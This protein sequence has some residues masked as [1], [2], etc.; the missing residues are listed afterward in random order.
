MITETIRKCKK[1]L[2]FFPLWALALFFACSPP[3]AADTLL[4]P[5]TQH[6]Q[7]FY[8]GVSTGSELELEIK[9][10]VKP[11]KSSPLPALAVA[12]DDTTSDSLHLYIDLEILNA[13]PE[14]VLLPEVADTL[15]LRVQVSFVDVPYKKHFDRGKL[16]LVAGWS[17]SGLQASETHEVEFAADSTL[18][19]SISL[20]RVDSFHIAENVAVYGEVL[21]PGRYVIARS[22][23]R[24]QAGTAAPGEPDLVGFVKDVDAENMRLYVSGAVVVITDSTRV[25]SSSGELITLQDLRSGR[26][27]FTI[28]AMAWAYRFGIGM[29]ANGWEF[30]R[31][32]VFV[33]RESTE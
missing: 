28:T 24:L 22:V 26:N 30:K 33:A 17:E 11:G 25:E 1:H 10:N 29:I 9:L 20:T 16:R 27:D 19:F 18:V 5:P 3:G 23:R 4:S 7:S 31:F 13:G 8:S 6:L 15:P 12:R 32:T 14:V 2:H 21:S